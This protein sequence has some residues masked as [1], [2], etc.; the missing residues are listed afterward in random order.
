MSAVWK[1]KW[2]VAMAAVVL[3]AVL[4]AVLLFLGVRLPKQPFRNLKPEDI[5]SARVELFPPDV[6]KDLPDD[7]LP[8]LAELLQDVVIYGPDD[9]HRLYA[10]Q[11]VVFT[12]TK[13]DG[14]V[15]EVAAF[16]PFCIINGV[17]YRTEYAPCEALND[18]ANGFAAE[19]YANME[20]NVSSWF[21]REDNGCP[22]TG[23]FAVNGQLL[24]F[25]LKNRDTAPE[26]TLHTA[27]DWQTKRI[28]VLLPQPA[29]N[30]AWRTESAPGAQLLGE[31]LRWTY[32]DAGTLGEGDC[33]H[34]QEF[35]FA[36][37][38][39]R[40]PDALCFRLVNTD[41]GLDEPVYFTLTLCLDWQAELICDESE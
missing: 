6:K 20:D 41:D 13:T 9:S 4:A 33:P 7:D 11:S 23:F 14:T 30:T 25:G 27:P 37:E 19:A 21:P 31:Q 16:N 36:V 39:D 40:L 17:G 28:A 22:D 5:L 29:N 1:R 38:E 12:I 10:G 2:R 3:L 24:P 8:A 32:P 34:L 26:E 35:I 15:L 18:F